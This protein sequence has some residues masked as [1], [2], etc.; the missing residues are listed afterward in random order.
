MS[1]SS[2]LRA[3]RAKY[4]T[5]REQVNQFANKLL[6]S[7][8]VYQNAHEKIKEAYKIDGDAGDKGV[9]KYSYESLK[10]SYELLNGSTIPS[11]NSKI[12]SLSHQIR[13]AE[14]KEEEEERKAKEEAEAKK[15]ASASD[16]VIY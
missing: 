1:S 12:D 5:F 6:Q 2:Q 13:A 16:Y 8:T 9:I 15:K 3:E 10:E 7:Y 11:I 14:A 4:Y